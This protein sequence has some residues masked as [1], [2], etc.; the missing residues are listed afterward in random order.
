MSIAAIHTIKSK[1]RMSDRDYR[2]LLMRVAGVTSS[3]QLTAEGDKAVVRALR[4]M[5]RDAWATAPKSRPEAKIWAL[6][7]GNDDRPGLI[8]Y[9]PAEKRNAQYLAGILKNFGPVE[10][11]GGI[12]SFAKFKPAQIR[13]AIE[14]LKTRL[15]Q[16]Q[17]KLSD[18]PF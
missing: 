18:V 15:D 13:K 7:L 5:E 17:D 8:R 4:A 16:E 14:A 12:L 3:K 11:H 1:L 10:W 9:L 6:W 2:A